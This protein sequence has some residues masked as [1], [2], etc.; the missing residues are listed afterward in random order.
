M[1]HPGWRLRYL[2]SEVWLHALQTLSILLRN[3][4]LGIACVWISTF[5]FS[6]GNVFS[7]RTPAQQTDFEFLLA[8]CVTIHTFF[9]AIFIVAHTP[10]LLPLEFAALLKKRRRTTVLFCVQRLARHSL[11]VYF[12]SL[13]FLVGVL[14]LLRSAPTALK[15]C[16]I[17]FYVSSICIHG[18]NV[19]LSVALRRIFRDETVIG[20][21]QLSSFR[22]D[23]TWWDSTKYYWKTWVRMLPLT[24][25]GVFAGLYVQLTSRYRVNGGWN[26]LWYTLGSLAFKVV[27]KEAAKFGIVRFNVQDPRTIFI[28]VG[29][30]TVLVDT[31]MR[32]MLQRV[33]SMRYAL[34]W[35]FG[36]AVL[37][38]STRL[39][40]V[41]WMKRTVARHDSKTPTTLIHVAPVSA[42]HHQDR[43]V[44]QDV[45]GA[46]ATAVVKR[47]G[48]LRDETRTIQWKIQMVAFQIAESYANMSGK[49]L[50]IGC[51][52]CIL[53]FYWDHQK[54]DLSGYTA[55]RSVNVNAQHRAWFQGSTLALQIAVEIAVDYISCVFEIGEG[56]DFQEVRRYGVFLALL[57]MCIASINIHICVLIYLSDG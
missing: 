47:F 57:F 25:A 27:I 35:T 39:S 24:L 26:L 43:N 10:V 23:S 31:Q 16:H 51:S 28:V 5:W 14:M 34:L 54:Y 44:S 18:Y 50:A 38:I 32:I 6:R 36:M 52:T 45:N 3:T 1:R 56:M 7:G 37:Q 48:S 20:H 8:T 33:R 19:S 11:A 17:E 55:S 40:K 41:L 29:L 15:K 42:A 30:P 12:W 4:C 49:Y 13:V 46:A 53:Y 9:Y 21:S 22:K 2:R